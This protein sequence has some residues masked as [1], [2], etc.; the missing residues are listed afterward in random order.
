[1]EQ[2]KIRVERVIV[3]IVEE[4]GERI[5]CRAMFLKKKTKGRMRV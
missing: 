2:D 3:K 5:Q 4:A 1:M